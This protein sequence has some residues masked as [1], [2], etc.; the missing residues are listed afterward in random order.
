MV[1]GL[2]LTVLGCSGTYPGP[3]GAC[4]GYLLRSETTAFLLDVGTGVLGPLQRHVPLDG[5]D[6]VVVT[7]GHPDHCLDLPVLRNALRYGLG[8]PDRGLPVHSPA[9]V[10]D[11][12]HGV[13]DTKSTFDWRI[14]TDGAVTA[15]GDVTVSFSRTD[16][17]GETLAVRCEHGGRAL[18]FSADTGPGWSFSVW[19]PVDVA[20]CEAA[21]ESD[22]E[23]SVQHLSARQ[24]G[25]AAHGAARL[26]LTHLVPGRDAVAAVDEAT[27]TFAGPVEV[28]EAGA[29]YEI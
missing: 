11:V 1:L 25:T 29:T 13:V 16:H 15:I 22:Q 6:G 20:L 23:G 2:T 18:G 9:W 7:H 27:A 10:R 14:A 19:G 3:G 24:A 8:Q 5:L 4:S 21:L 28:V 12:V 26:L 17:P